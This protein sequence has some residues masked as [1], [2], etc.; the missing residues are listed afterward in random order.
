MYLV[1]VGRRIAVE[2][3]RPGLLFASLAVLAVLLD[4][5]SKLYI[6]S[7]MPPSTS[8]PVIEGVFHITHVRNMGAAFGLMPGKQPL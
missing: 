6:R 8:I 4:Q 5:A 1:Q 2:A 7:T 3:R